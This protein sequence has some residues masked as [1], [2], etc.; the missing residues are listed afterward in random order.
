M[1]GLGDLTEKLYNLPNREAAA[2]LNL[3][4]IPTIR[5]EVE[6]LQQTIV[7][8]LAGYGNEI[9]PLIAQEIDV[10]LENYPWQRIVHETIEAAVTARIQ[11]FFEMGEGRKAIDEAIKAA[12][13]LEGRP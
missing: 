6:H 12:F 7:R 2:P 1:P 3:M 11:R 5:V 4:G 13:G 10:A 9:G 8:A